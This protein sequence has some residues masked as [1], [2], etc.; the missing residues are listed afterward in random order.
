EIGETLRETF[1][2]LHLSTG[3]RS[4]LA[5]A[6][7]GVRTTLFV[8]RGTQKGFQ[9]YPKNGSP[10]ILPVRQTCECFRCQGSTPSSFAREALLLASAPERR[11]RH[12]R[13]RSGTPRR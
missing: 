4:R 2:R 3:L 1:S 8:H 7:Y 10:C 9:W 6:P 13:M 5:Q 12:S 11:Q